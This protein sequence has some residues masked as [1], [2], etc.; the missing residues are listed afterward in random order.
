[1]IIIGREPAN[2]DR[3]LQGY[4]PRSVE[5]AVLQT[6]G[7]S[8]SRYQFSTE[9]RL[10]FELQLRRALVDASV[11]LGRSRLAFRIFRE[12]TCNPEY[13][14]RTPEGGFSLK[15][16]VSAWAAIQDIY[17][18]SGM[19]G[20]ECATAMMIVYYK[21]LADVFPA[22][23]FDRMFPRIYL[24]NWHAIPPELREVGRTR[25]VED[26]M[27]GDRRYFRNP[28]VNPETPEWQGENVIDVGGGMYY[29]HGMGIHNAQFILNALNQNR[30]ADADEEA[31]LL[32]GAGRPDFNRLFSLYSRA[33]SRETA[34]AA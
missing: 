3:L 14:N 21:A 25:R 29:G 22:E 27:P 8:S 6:M 33:A 31:Y 18:N 15:P 28:D 20:T 9:E 10:R 34:G 2:M 19:Y 32:D 23:A 12:S 7:N 26:Y 24:M 5:R 17:R 13:W 30:A 1:M 4:H 11:A 16:G